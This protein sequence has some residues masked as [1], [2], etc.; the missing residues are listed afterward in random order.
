[1]K[2]SFLFR[3]AGMHSS[4]LWSNKFIRCLWLFVSAAEK[5]P[6]GEENSGPSGSLVL[7]RMDGNKYRFW[8]DVIIGRP[9][10][11]RGETDGTITFV[12]DTAS[13]DNTY[14]D[15]EHPCILKFKLAGNTIISTACPLHLTADLAMA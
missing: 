5:P 2:G 15:A 8:L 13:F 1:M 3:F 12:N 7:V 6:K 9:D 11:N 14:E 4:C 10:Y